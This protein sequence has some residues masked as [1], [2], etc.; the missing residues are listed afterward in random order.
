MSRLFPAL[1]TLLSVVLLLSCDQPAGRHA[2]DHLDDLNLLKSRLAAGDTA[3]A[4]D[5]IARVKREAAD[6]Q[7]YYHGVELEARLW[8]AMSERDSFNAAA[9]RLDRFID[10]QHA[11]T[12]GHTLLEALAQLAKGAY[13]AR[14][15]G[16]PDTAIVFDRRA[17]DIL[18]QLPPTPRQQD[19]MLLALSNTADALMQQGQMVQTVNCYKQAAHIIDSLGRPEREKVPIW[20]GL[21]VA[22]TNMG[23]FYQ[24]NRWWNLVAVYAD[25]LSPKDRFLYL[26]NRGNDLY[27]QQRYDE[28]MNLFRQL[29]SMT[30]GRPD[31]TL[32]RIFGRTNM[33]D[34]S[35]RLGQM[36]Q[37]AQ[38]LD[39]VDS[40]FTLHPMPAAQY[41]IATLRIDQAVKQGQTTLPPAIDR[42]WPVVAGVPPQQRLQRM[43]AM[44]NHYA[45]THQQLPL[46]TTRVERLML[47]DSLHDD[48]MRMRFQED[49]TSYLYL[50]MLDVREQ[51]LH[52]QQHSS[53]RAW[54]L[55]AALALVVLL[56]T[57]LAWLW[58]RNA[59]LKRRAEQQQMMALQNSVEHLRL[60]NLRNRM[61][62]HFLSNALTAPLL[63]QARG[64]T[65]QLTPLVQLLHQGLR[66]M[67]VTTVP[68]EE[69]LDFLRAYVDVSRQSFSF[70]YAE[71]IGSD[72]DT[73]R[74]KVPSMLLQI[75]AENALKHG[76]RSLPASS[77]RER[78]IVVSA[79]ADR[80]GTTIR[81][82]DT[83]YGLGYTQHRGS[84]VGLDAIHQT[85]QLLNRGRR[86]PLTFS[87]DNR[88]DPGDGHP[89]G[90]QATLFVPRDFS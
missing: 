66:L 24:S 59:Q 29:D 65:P 28:S 3:G 45:A 35:L 21:A 57:L 34:L 17:I 41:Y 13:W 67:S 54:A 89:G 60:E 62:P 7:D 16:R 72:V 69:E 79:E 46:A 49:V 88:D 2:G 12:G 1:V 39:E 22:Y 25:S 32:E 5:V 48:Q 87:M 83:G 81:V 20:M 78:A 53:R 80:R 85:L 31:L 10:R 23:N 15:M 64:E 19:E 75:M 74:V 11:T 86:T 56:L 90:C 44:E 68:L 36:E 9:E 18:Q 4:K 42:R 50:R 61:T 73:A 47:E 30:A 58:Y 76:L 70:S 77:T 71:Q 84:Q 40:F 27:L 63:A 82:T 43:Q 37:A 8:F 51:L 52:E 14:V 26:N 6:S 55:L 33:A 38:L